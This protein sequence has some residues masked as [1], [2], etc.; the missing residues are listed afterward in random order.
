MS[1]NT[2]HITGI[3][4]HYSAHHDAVAAEVVRE[5]RKSAERNEPILKYGRKAVDRHE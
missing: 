1:S 2:A 4:G 5:G 3:A